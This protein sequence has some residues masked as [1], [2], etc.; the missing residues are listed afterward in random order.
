MTKP[1]LQGLSRKEFIA[2]GYNKVYSACT[3]YFDALIKLKNNS[4]HESEV[5][6]A[7]GTAATTI[8]GLAQAYSP[9]VG[10]TSAGFGLISNY[11]NSYDK[12]ELLTPYPDETKGLI[13]DAM[14]LYAEKNPPTNDL[15]TDSGAL[16]RVYQYAEMC[17][18]SGISRYAK[19]TLTKSK[20]KVDEE[21][22]NGGSTKPLSSVT[23]TSNTVTGAAA[24]AATQAANSGAPANAVGAA[25]AAAGAAT[26]AGAPKIA[27]EAAGIAAANA[28]SLPGATPATI[29]RETTNAAISAGAPSAAAT[30]AGAA[31]GATINPKSDATSVGIAAT[32][33]NAAS[34]AG[35]PAAAAAAGIAASEAVVHGASAEAIGQAAK[36]AA[37][38]AGA[39]ENAANAAEDAASAG[40]F[41][42]N[43]PSVNQPSDSIKSISPN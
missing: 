13:L 42:K 32:T 20:P 33:A 30:S 4:A 40:S 1:N 17:T 41:E 7:V 2:A 8:M 43:I 5:S 38:S 36:D 10:I 6:N 23:S 25:A 27:A 28:A 12:N 31:A 34:N 9:A 35:A 16:A 14:R 29:S 19:E 26:N 37:T 15:L 3:E 11:F 22:K 21:S 18:Y 24:D 39:N